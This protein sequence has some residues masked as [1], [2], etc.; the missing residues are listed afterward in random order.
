MT[1][2]KNTASCGIWMK[3]AVTGCKLKIINSVCSIH[4]WKQIRS[5]CPPDFEERRNRLAAFDHIQE[6]PLPDGLRGEL[7]PYQRHG[8]D[9]LHFL[10]EYRFGGILA[11]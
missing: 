3:A 11:R 9:W 6:H 10:H 2:C 1:G 8:V 7:R 4:C 5:A